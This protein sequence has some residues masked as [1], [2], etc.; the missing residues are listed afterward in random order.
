MTFKTT[1]A[2]AASFDEFYGK[3][4]NKAFLQSKYEGTGSRNVTISECRQD[5]DVFRVVWAREVPSNP[6]AFARKFLAEWNSLHETIEWSRKGDG[7]AFG[8]YKCKTSGVPGVLE[9]KF[10]LRSEGSGCVEKITMK[11][12]VRIPIL[13]KKIAAIVESETEDQLDKEYAF[14]RSELGES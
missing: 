5:G 13:G 4:T 9:G 11:A 10:D 3:L 6:P 1:H 2:Y 7:S 14:S 8:D 12:T